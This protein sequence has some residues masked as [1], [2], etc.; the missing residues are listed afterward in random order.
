M[1]SVDNE[2][3]LMVTELL[4]PLGTIRP[5][6]MF[7]GFG[8]YCDGMFF[9]LVFDDVLYLKGDEQ[10]Q[11]TY[12]KIG[13]ARFVVPSQK[14]PHTIAYFEAPG[15]WLDDQDRLLE[16]AQMAFGAAL[17]AQAAKKRPK[18]SAGKRSPREK[19]P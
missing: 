16:F 3:V 19:K 11:A 8:L 10:T 5:R 12:D 9:A 2:F 13:M 6:R 14:A 4:S 15:E 17:R 1:A 7:G 18:K